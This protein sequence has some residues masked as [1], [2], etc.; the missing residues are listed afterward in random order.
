MLSRLL[1][2]T[3]LFVAG[4]GDHVVVQSSSTGGAPWETSVVGTKDSA[5]TL[6]PTIEVT[7]TEHVFDV[8][9]VNR[10][11]FDAE[12]F[13]LPLDVTGNAAGDAIALHFDF[14]DGE[15]TTSV[16]ARPFSLAGPGT[17]RVLLRV[18]P[19][20]DGISLDIGGQISGPI[21]ERLHK[22]TEP[23]PTAADGTDE[24]PAPT[25]ASE[26]CEP[27]PTAAD[28]NNEEPAPTAAR[29]KC[30]P[31]PT[32]ADGDGDAESAYEPAPTAADGEE[33]PPSSEPA[34]TAAEP[35]PTAAREKTSIDSLE[36]D[37]DTLEEAEL[38]VSSRQ[39]FDFYAG[40]VEIGLGDRELLVTWDV[41]SWLRSV[42]SEPLGIPDGPTSAPA[43]FEEPGFDEMQES[44]ELS[45]L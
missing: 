5:L 6:V 25:A 44:F 30:E 45:T 35:A 27:A 31:A 34:P 7:G 14:E 3:L 18:H 10:L 33:N 1:T 38:S 22:A 29:E 8:L 23:A 4:C 28:G 20:D 26:K 41:R 13:L 9:D 21:V 11:S 24:E 40:V 36:L 43:D 16:S 15:E 12:L 2:L 37:S 42:L 39:E 19:A 17:Y 32:A